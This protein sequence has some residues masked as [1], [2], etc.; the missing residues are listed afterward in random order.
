MI[1]KYTQYIK[2]N[3]NNND[4][5]TTYE[6]TKEWLDKMKIDNYTINDDLTVHVNGNV[7][8]YKMNLNFLPVKFSIVN[9]YFE[10]EFNNLPNLIGSPEKLINSSSFWY[11][12]NPLTSL[13][14]LSIYNLKIIIDKHWY[15]GLKSKI[16]EDYFDTILEENPEI[17]NLIDFKPSKKFKEKWEHLFNATKFDLI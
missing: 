13:E 6:E 17:F 8:L 15:V 1:T 11:G 4:F 10:V 16:K 9:G 2:E 12:A 5:F 14:G 7:H 3:V